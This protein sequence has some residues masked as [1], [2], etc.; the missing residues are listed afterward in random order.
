MLRRLLFLFVFLSL[1]A[2]AQ[3]VP[4]EMCGTWTYLSGGQ[5]SY[6]GTRTLTLSADGTYQYYSESSSSGSAGSYYGNNS[7][8]GTWYV[9][10]N[11]IYGNSQSEGPI[12][13]PF[14]MYPNENG[15][16]VLDIDGDVYVR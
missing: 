14:S 9:Q 11:M 7:D 8:A 10:G 2:W 3:S 16:I 12:E 4:P 15:D 1:P 13:L 5:G 6:M